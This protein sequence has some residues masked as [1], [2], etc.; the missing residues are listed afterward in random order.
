[1]LRRYKQFVTLQSDLRALAEHVG[2]SGK[3]TGISSA[4]SLDTSIGSAPALPPDTR[5]STGVASSRTA[6]GEGDDGALSEQRVVGLTGSARE[7]SDGEVGPRGLGYVPSV[8]STGA[9]A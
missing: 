1:M 9:A 4:D 2:L 5:G 3:T 8:S 7:S 6:A